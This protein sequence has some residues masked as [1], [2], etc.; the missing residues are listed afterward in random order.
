[1]QT[2]QLRRV[3]V[4][5]TYLDLGKGAPR[6]IA[7]PHLQAGRQLLLGQA[8]PFPEGANTLADALSAE[9]FFPDEKP[10]ETP[11]PEKDSRQG[12]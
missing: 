10:S 9:V 11:L 8:L 5:L 6:H 2:L 4:P 7:T 3:D 1:M 12:R